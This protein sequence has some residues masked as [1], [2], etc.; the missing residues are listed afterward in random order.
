MDRKRLTLFHMKLESDF[1]P[2][3]FSS[4]VSGSVEPAA[5][6]F[7]PQCR[8]QSAAGHAAV[9]RRVVVSAAEGFRLSL[10]M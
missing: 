5:A 1:R 4:S 2:A 8:D 7:C 9:Y 3:K 10:N 6:V